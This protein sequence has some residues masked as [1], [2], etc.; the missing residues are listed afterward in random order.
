MPIFQK[1]IFSLTVLCLILLFVTACTSS[2]SVPSEAAQPASQIVLK[3]SGSGSTTAVIDVIQPA[4]EADMPEYRLVV[5]PGT[6]TGGGVK[7]IVQGVLDVAAMARPPKDNDDERGVEY[8]EFGLAGQAIITHLDMDISNLT[9]DQVVAIFSGEITNWSEVG[10]P[11]QSIILYVR[12]EGDSSTKLLRSVMMGDTPFADSVAKVLTSQGEM[13]RII[14]GTPGSIGIATWPTALAKGAEI[15]ALTIDGVAPGDP[16][17]L[18]MGPLGI[19]YLPDR[20]ADVQP[21]I[22]WL[23]S[24]QGRQALSQYDVIASFNR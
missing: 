14:A 23:S 12:D 7:G 22:N 6:G 5:L 18:M 9:E 13:L 16:N 4:F 15:Q 3:V 8:V 20:A 1:R 10:G 24:D 11:D 17:Y 21:L 2:A 19:G